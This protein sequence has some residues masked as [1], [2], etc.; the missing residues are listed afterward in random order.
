VGPSQVHR[1]LDLSIRLGQTRDGRCN[2]EASFSEF[3][4][5]PQAAQPDGHICKS[6]LN[7]HCPACAAESH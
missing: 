5:P 4:K 3:A 1:I 6:A 2:L 7:G